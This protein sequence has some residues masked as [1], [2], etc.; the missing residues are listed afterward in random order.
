MLGLSYFGRMRMAVNL[1]PLLQRTPPGGLRRV[2]SAFAGAH[3]GKV[4]EDDWQARKG[5]IPARAARGHAAAMMTLGL[6]A[7][8][9]RAPGISFVH[10]FPGSVKTSL[11]RGDE[12]FMMQVMKY[13]F[14]VV[15][16][17][18]GHVPLPEV[19]ERHAFYCTSA[20]YPA[21]EGDGRGES[22]GI[23]LPAVVDV[24][25]GI[26]GKKGSGVYTIDAQGESAGTDVMDWHARYRIDGTADRLWEYTESEFER[27]TGHR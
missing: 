21:R 16:F 9:R 6:A 7:L 24:A 10:D 27:V 11:I 13:A 17:L 22:E 23:A 26:D 5:T 12:G 25:N 18:K 8:A 20:K 1:L 15:F 14:A 3:D 4:Y 2:V 19:G